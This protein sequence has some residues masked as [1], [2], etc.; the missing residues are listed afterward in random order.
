MKH[1]RDLKSD[2]RDRDWVRDLRL[3]I[4]AFRLSMNSHVEIVQYISLGHGRK[5][6]SS[7]DRAN[8]SRF[9]RNTEGER[10]VCVLWLR[11]API[12]SP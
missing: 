12:R 8:C 11:E 9:E 10:Y 1:S 5:S 7:C 2:P 3:E 4:T 6:C